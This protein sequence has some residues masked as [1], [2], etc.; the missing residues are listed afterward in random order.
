MWVLN[1]TAIFYVRPEKPFILF[2]QQNKKRKKNRKR[3]R[4][5]REMFSLFFDGRKKISF[6]TWTLRDSEQINKRENNWTDR[7]KLN[8]KLREEM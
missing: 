6:R 7:E 1:R 3:K 2:R 8:Q 4:N 5:N